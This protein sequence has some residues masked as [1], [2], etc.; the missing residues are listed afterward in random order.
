M[1]KSVCTNTISFFTIHFSAEIM[2]L[3]V[4]ICRTW[5]AI[6]FPKVIQELAVQSIP[7]IDW[8]QQSMSWKPQ[9]PV[10]SFENYSSCTFSIFID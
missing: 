3:A 9:R 2:A 7:V 4:S 1:L 6:N 10:C 8:L 5:I